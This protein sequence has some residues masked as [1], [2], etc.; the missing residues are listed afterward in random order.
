MVVPKALL[1][2]VL[3]A[4][5]DAVLTL[6]SGLMP[7][8]ALVARL[9]ERFADDPVLLAL[10]FFAAAFLDGGCSAGAADCIA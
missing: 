1:A 7:A 2:P 5:F 3:A 8:L 4:D 10:A 9:V 6:L